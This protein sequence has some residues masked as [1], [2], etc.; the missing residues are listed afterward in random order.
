[1]RIAGTLKSTKFLF[2]L[3]SLLFIIICSSRL[4]AQDNSLDKYQIIDNPEASAFVDEARSYVQQ[5]YGMPK[6][7]INTVTLRYCPDTGPFTNLTDE[8]KGIFTICLTHKPGEYSFYGQ[9]AHETGHLLNARL[10]DAYGEGLCTFFSRQ[11]IEK[12]GK[13]WRGWENYYK[14]GVEPFYSST[15]FMMKE[16]AE[17]AG[18][19]DI[20]TFFS[21]AKADAHS[22][23]RMHIDIKSW[24]NSLPIQKQQQ[25]KEIILNHS[26]DVQATLIG[27]KRSYSFIIPK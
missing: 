3:V 25:V 22:S 17:A 9:L 15:Y 1:M 19:E 10:F 16:V 23:N 21:F 18:A 11:L 14:D 20:K 24:I 12:T 26:K 27:P 2:G 6:V 5:L 4:S 13:D 8:K 7:S